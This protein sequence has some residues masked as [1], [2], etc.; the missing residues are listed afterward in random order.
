MKNDLIYQCCVCGE[1]WIYYHGNGNGNKERGFTEPETDE[2]L[3]FMHRLEVLAAKIERLNL[4][5]KELAKMKIFINHGLCRLCAR[6]MLIPIRRKK[7]KQEGR[8]ECFASKNS[9][10]CQNLDCPYRNYCFATETELRHWETRKKQRRNL[11]QP[12][13]L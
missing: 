5:P 12:R 6:E 7:Q 4:G 3:H 2:E 10:K 8:P 13:P 1:V 9:E 11:N